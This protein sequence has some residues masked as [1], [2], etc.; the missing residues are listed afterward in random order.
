MIEAP[1]RLVTSFLR[2]RSIRWLEITV[3][4]LFAYVPS[5]FSQAFESKHMRGPWLPYYEFF[6]GGTVLAVLLLLVWIADRNFERI[7]LTRFRLG[8]DMLIGIGLCMSFFVAYRT[9]VTMIPKDL[10]EYWYSLGKP[11]PIQEEVTSKLSLWVIMPPLFVINMF[12]EVLMRGYLTSRLTDLLPSKWAPVFLSSIIFAMWHVYEGPLGVMNAF[13]IGLVLGTVFIYTKRLWP[14][15][16]A[17]FT[18]DAIVTLIF[19]AYSSKSG[20]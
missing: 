8:W 17:H 9:I 13:T 3:V 1:P 7:G 20:R 6:S 19:L 16:I 2:P 10:Y 18:F 12:E 4:L 15:I 14:L 5:A 11:S